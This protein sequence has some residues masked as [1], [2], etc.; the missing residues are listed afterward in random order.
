M[1]A[2]CIIMVHYENDYKWGR[3][4]E[5]KC[6][7]IVAE[8]FGRNIVQ[9]VSQYDKWDG[10]CSVANYELKSRHIASD[11]HESCMISF[12]KCGME[13]G[14]QTILLF[15]YTDGLYYVEYNDEVF[16]NSKN[17]IFCRD[18]IAGA[19]KMTLYIPRRFLQVIKMWPREMP[20]I[21][22]HLQAR[23][24]IIDVSAM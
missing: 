19:E 15:N 10:R 22:K 21:F 9:S 7:P 6:F 11:T 13:E 20:A 14:K 17:E 2:N 8:F 12:N 5:D 18:D 3:E 16:K 1:S 4:Q 24:C 23:K